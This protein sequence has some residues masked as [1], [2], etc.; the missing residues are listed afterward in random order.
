MKNK[1][2]VELNE[3][4][5]AQE[6]LGARRPVVVQFWAGWSEPSKAMTP[7]LESVAEDDA[8]PV[9]VGR[10]NVEFHEDLAEDYGVRCVP[11]VMFFN[12]GGL[13]DEI[14]GRA[15]EQEVRAKLEQLK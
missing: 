12:Q 13:Q 4:N 15:S 10:V 2:I 11:T 1:H 6:V 3:A 14:V 9:K 7:L 8:A 5:F